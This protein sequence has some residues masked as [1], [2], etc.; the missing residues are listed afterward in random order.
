MAN[1]TDVL[2]ILI[3]CV[4]LIRMQTR[5]SYNKVF[6]PSAFFGCELKEQNKKQTQKAPELPT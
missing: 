6:K 1:V 4:R 2:N 3:Q 5:Y